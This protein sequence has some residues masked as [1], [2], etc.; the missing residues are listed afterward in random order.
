[1]D[2]DLSVRS[3][4]HGQVEA[5]LGHKVLRERHESQRATQ[6]DLLEHGHVAS[7][8]PGWTEVAVLTTRSLGE[9]WRPSAVMSVQS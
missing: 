9:S 8:R 5:D 7:G 1:M 4:R 2:R 6:A 3:C